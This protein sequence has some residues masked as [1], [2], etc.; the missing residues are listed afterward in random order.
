MVTPSLRF[1]HTP[2]LVMSSLADVRRTLT[3]Y[4]A[5]KFGKIAG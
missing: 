5:G 2:P 3:D 1:P 4:T